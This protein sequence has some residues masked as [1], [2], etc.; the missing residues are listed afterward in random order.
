MT[1][2]MGLH[3]STGVR[4][5]RNTSFPGYVW[6]ARRPQPPRHHCRTRHA[7]IDGF[8]PRSTET[9]GLFSDMTSHSLRR[10]VCQSRRSLGR[11]REENRYCFLSC[12]PQLLVSPRW[13][14]PVG[15][16]SLRYEDGRINQSEATT[17]ASPLRV[18]SVMNALVL[19]AGKR[20]HA[21]VSEFSVEI[22]AAGSRSCPRPRTNSSLHC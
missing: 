7:D 21:S 16:P 22:G 13:G 4:G 10:G 1:P 9:G 3:S 2:A 5:A 20:R 14:P 19:R 11:E 12:F 17:T 15:L 6:R 18:F 8:R